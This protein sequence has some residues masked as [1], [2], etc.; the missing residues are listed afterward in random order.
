MKHILVVLILAGAI[1]LAQGQDISYFKKNIKELSS[2]KYGGRGYDKDNDGKAAQYIADEFANAGAKVTFQEI[3]FPINDFNGKVDFFVD[4]KKLRPG[5]DYSLSTYSS[6]A[7]GTFK[8]HYIDSAAFD[9]NK[10]VEFLKDK[11]GDLV[12]IL[13][14][15]RDARMLMMKL[16]SQKIK[17]RG[18]IIRNGREKAAT[19]VQVSGMGDEMSEVSPVMM[20]KTYT[21]MISLQFPLFVVDKKAFSVNVKEVAFDVETHLTKNEKSSNV[22][23]TIQGNIYPDSIFVFTAHYDHLGMLGTQVFYPGAND[24]ASGTSMLLSLADYYGKPENKPACTL[25]FLATTGE[26]MGLLGS[27]EFVNNPP[28]NLKNIKYLL[29]F[30]MVA[31]QA[32]TLTTYSDRFAIRGYDLVKAINEKEGLFKTVTYAKYQQNSD[33]YPF[34]LRGVPAICFILEKGKNFNRL[35]TPDDNADHISYLSFSKI[36]RLATEFVKQ[37]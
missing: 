23:A 8:T 17:L 35:H 25:V 2:E 11:G 14:M 27:K 33:H 10:T 6:S 20:N 31:D 37:Y 34:L 29:N 36:F 24:N 30:D 7:K 32:D 16:S 19:L 18:M 15:S 5:Y 3:T 1:S 4:G 22:I 12:I 9:M 13:N 26:E 21:N 28:F